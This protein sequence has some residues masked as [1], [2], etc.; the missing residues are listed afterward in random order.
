MVVFKE[1][2]FQLEKLPAIRN[3]QHNRE[4]S[5]FSQSLSIIVRTLKTVNKLASVE[6]LVHP[7][8][9]KLGSLRET[10][11][12]ANDDW[13]KWSLSELAEHLR[14]FV[15]RNNLNSEKWGLENIPG[16]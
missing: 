16:I 6:G 9:V 13:E 15:D 2:V 12:A 1:L 14:K 8:F 3:V 4:I 11:T 5:E 7:T 10:L